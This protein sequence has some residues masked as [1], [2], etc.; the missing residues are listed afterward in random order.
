MADNTDLTLGAALGQGAAGAATGAIAGGPIGAIIGGVV[1]IGSSLLTSWLEGES[2]QRQ[3]DER[4]R[5]IDEQLG[6]KREQAAFS[7]K[8]FEERLGLQREQ[9]GEQVT[10]SEQ[11]MQDTTKD[12]QEQRFGSFIN[13]G[14]AQTAAQSLGRRVDQLGLRG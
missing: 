11:Q 2:I 5:I 8:I 9:F 12:I 13:R 3:A 14:S 6:L 7:D 10:R 1:G 4:S